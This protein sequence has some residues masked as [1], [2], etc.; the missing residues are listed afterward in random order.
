MNLELNGCMAIV[1][2]ASKS[3][4]KACFLSLAAEGA[5]FRFAGG[6]EE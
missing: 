5:T 3:I 4:G 2:V 6:V 1:A